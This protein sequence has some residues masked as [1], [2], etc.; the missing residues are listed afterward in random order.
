M[1]SNLQPLQRIISETV[2]P[3]S[4][5]LIKGGIHKGYTAFKNYLSGGFCVYRPK[6]Q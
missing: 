1:S 5:T 3:P 2:S 4:I 6:N